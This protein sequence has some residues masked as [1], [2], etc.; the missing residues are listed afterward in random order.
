MR[1][2][3]TN[4]FILPLLLAVILAFT[5]CS[6]ATTLEAQ[7]PVSAPTQDVDAP[8]PACINNTVKYKGKTLYEYYS[9]NPDTIGWL[10]IDG[11]KTDN[12]VMLGQKK[13][14]DQGTNGVHHYLDRTFDHQQSTAGELYMDF[15]ADVDQFGINQNTTIYGHHMRD[16]TMLAGLDGYMRKSYYN[17]HQ[18]FT[19]HSL[20]NTY[21]FR[22]FSVFI[23][24]MKV[25]ED[26]DFEFR[27][28]TYENQED[29]LE[30]IDALKARSMYDT[31]VQV[32][33]ND[34]IMN[35]ITCTYPTGNPAVDDA[36]L[37]VVGRLCTDQEEIKAA[38]AAL[39]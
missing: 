10:T 20:W 35:L 28:P 30:L 5:G 14:Y 34:R 21:H 32:K 9:E 2:L 11:T 37:V 31:D 25:K 7:P 36:R 1:K 22:V 12:V 26:K 6:A 39:K 23:I 33:E 15:R 24:N 27:L 3:K 8:V 16:G 17:D 19:F 29:F 13:N 18:Y 38:E 4:S